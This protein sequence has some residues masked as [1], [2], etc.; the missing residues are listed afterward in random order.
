MG[1]TQPSPSANEELRR[2][3]DTIYTSLKDEHAGALADYIPE[4]AKADPDSFGLSIATASGKLVC[5]GDTER[6]FTIQSISKAFTYCIALELCGHAAVVERVGVEPSGDAFN[7]IE[8]DPHTRRPFN[9]MVNAGA[10]TVAGLLYRELGEKAFDHVLDRFSHAAGRQ[11]EVDQAVYESEALTGHRNRAIAH[12]LL[13]TGA[14]NGPVEPVVDLYFRQ[15]AIL[16]NSRDL[17]WMGATL[18]HFGENPLTG[19]QVFDLKPIRDTLS[20]MFSCGM[21]DYSGNWA[22]DV[23][24][25]AK[26]GV[27]GGI[28]GVINRQMGIGSYSPRLDS[29]GNS[30]RGVKA[31][32]ALS[33]E[34]GLHAFECTNSGSAVSK[35]FV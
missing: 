2:L 27:G 10:I 18:A 14:L 6:G 12:L 1:E 20:V 25:P 19:R 26:S 8:F 31:F 11:L 15:C 33:D 16:V 21:Y 28:L 4:L 29:K 34:L 32:A 9:P 13:A 17:A 22:F 24:V 3:L 5:A 35:R 7:A 23:G 30:V